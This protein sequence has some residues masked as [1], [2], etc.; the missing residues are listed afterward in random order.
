M[1]GATRVRTFHLSAHVD[2]VASHRTPM[3]AAIAEAERARGRT[4]DNPWV[5]CAICDES[6]AIVALGHTQGPGEDHAEIIAIDAARR[7]G[8]DLGRTTLYCTLEPCS[9]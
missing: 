1:V 7:R 4:G 2:H 8:V 9:F 5:G 3:L 6:G